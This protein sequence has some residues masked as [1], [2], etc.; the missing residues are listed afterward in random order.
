MN[1]FSVGYLYSKRPPALQQQRAEMRMFFSSS[2]EALFFSV[3]CARARAMFLR[4]TLALPLCLDSFLRE[5]TRREKK[6]QHQ[7]NNWTSLQRWLR[8]SLL[9][10]ITSLYCPLKVSWAKVK[11]KFEK[12]LNWLQSKVRQ[13]RTRDKH[14]IYDMIHC[15]FTLFVQRVETFFFTLL[16]EVLRSQEICKKKHTENCCSAAFGRHTTFNIRVR[17]RLCA[18]MHALMRRIRSF[19]TAPAATTA[20]DIHWWKAPFPVSACKCVYNLSSSMLSMRL[21]EG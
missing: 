17:E 3:S 13:D 11:Q 12:K 18:R 5:K 6:R 8:L 16:R 2:L 20:N 14:A 9:F 10:L 19:T 1:P 4:F 15:W 21:D 7:T